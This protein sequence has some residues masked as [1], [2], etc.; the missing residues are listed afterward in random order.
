M[1]YSN[2]VW[3]NLTN[4]LDN[5]LEK[6]HRNAARVITG[7]TV[8]CSKDKLFQ[9]TGW[10]TLAERRKIRRLITMYKIVNGLAPKYLT[11]LLPDTVENNTQINLRNAPNIKIQLQNRTV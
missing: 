11:D 5:Q 9:E 10:K 7:L 8:S 3:G 1:E 4:E 2:T 6:I